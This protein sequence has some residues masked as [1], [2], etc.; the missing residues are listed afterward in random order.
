MFFYLVHTD[1]QKFN[2]SKFNIGIK[3]PIEN[4]KAKLVKIGYKTAK[5]IDYKKR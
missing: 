4:E 3:Q 2:K 1:L 5:I